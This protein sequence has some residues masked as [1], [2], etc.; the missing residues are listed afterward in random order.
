MS[1]VLSV[2][3]SVSFILPPSF[4]VFS[5]PL[6][7][8]AELLLLS[9]C[10]PIALS[11]RVVEAIEHTIVD[12]LFPIISLDG[13]FSILYLIVQ[14]PRYVLLYPYLYCCCVEGL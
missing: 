5:P 8:G 14:A 4:P 13:F 6:L 9:L 1:S 12:W 10:D 7:L 11:F 2:F 3:S